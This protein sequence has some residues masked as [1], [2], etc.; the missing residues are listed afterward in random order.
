MPCGTARGSP[1]P[2]TAIGGTGAGLHASSRH[3][4]RPSG[5]GAPPSPQKVSGPPQCLA[6]GWPPWPPTAL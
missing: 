6:M 5:S 2:G 1:H 4:G 3:L